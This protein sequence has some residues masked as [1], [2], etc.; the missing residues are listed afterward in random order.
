MNLNSSASS[1]NTFSPAFGKIANTT[2]N[3]TIQTTNKDANQKETMSDVAQ[4][5][6]S[7]LLDVIMA[8]HNNLQDQKTHS[9]L[10]YLANKLQ[11]DKS[12]GSL[13][14]RKCL[15]LDFNFSF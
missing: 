3:T 14:E 2:M 12:D 1:L 4:S 13:T 6:R 10:L 5:S 11:N 15:K 7:S 8:R 9:K